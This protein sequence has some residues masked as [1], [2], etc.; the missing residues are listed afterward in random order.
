MSIG[1]EKQGISAPR[2]RVARYAALLASLLCVAQTSSSTGTIEAGAMRTDTITIRSR[3]DCPAGSYIYRVS[4][5]RDFLKFVEPRFS[6]E[7]NQRKPVKYVLDAAGLEPGTYSATIK[8]RCISCLPQ[9]IPELEVEEFVLTVVPVEQPDAGILVAPGD[10]VTLKIGVRIPDLRGLTL[11]EARIQA[12]PLSLDVIRTS[13]GEDVAE[14]SA[15]PGAVVT[16][17]QPAPGVLVP[18]GTTIQLKVMGSATS[19]GA[20]IALALI[21]A[22]ALLAVMIRQWRR[23]LRTAAAAHLIMRT[24]P[25]AGVQHIS[26]DSP[27]LPRCS[28]ML[29]VRRGLA[30]HVVLGPPPTVVRAEP[31]GAD[32]NGFVS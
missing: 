9:C 14:T 32:T 11:R 1:E 7:P 30:E 29:R 4:A 19:P 5:N 24:Q 17:Q 15:G 26:S 21:V 2:A 22:L 18:T 13:D 20:L 6:L 3:S 8:V 28:V 31:D 12:R 23:R 27:P 25:D 10:P 16:S